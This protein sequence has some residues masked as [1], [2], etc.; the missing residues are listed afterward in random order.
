MEM[1][2]AAGEKLGYLTGD[3]PQPSK[4]SSTYSKW[5]T[6]NFQVKG[7]LIDS[8]SPDLM[9]RFILLSTAKE[10]WD[11]VK[12][13]YFDGGDETFLFD[14]NKRAFTIKQ[15]DAPTKLDRLSVHLF[16]AG[17]DPQFDQVPGEI[18]RKEPKLDLDQ[19]FAYVRREAQQRLTI[20]STPDTAVLATQCPQGPP[21]STT[22]AS[23]T[24]VTSSHPERKCTHCGGSKHTRDGC[25]ELIGYP[26]W[27]D[28][29]KAPRKNRGKSLDTS[30]DSAPVS[31]AVQ[32]APAPASTSVVT[33]G[34]PQQQDDWLWY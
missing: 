21:T 8:M 16:L 25:Y 28:H 27:W 20:T 33:T 32:T 26:D 11:A 7:W 24:Q 3:T 34:H 19:I 15:N 29:S 12:K 5:C 9:S 18:L 6:E 13:T 2:I 22:G 17:L 31:P 4:L 10:I 14:L 1:R 23:Q 30:S